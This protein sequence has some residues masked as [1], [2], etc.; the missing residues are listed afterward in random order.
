VVRY[1]QSV[2][3]PG[4]ARVLVDGEIVLEGPIANEEDAAGARGAAA[5]RAYDLGLMPGRFD[6][7]PVPDVVI[8]EY[9]PP[10]VLDAEDPVANAA[11]QAAYVKSEWDRL[12]NQHLESIRRAQLRLLMLGWSGPT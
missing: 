10:P 5:R 12:W 4:I 1:E 3:Y 6:G 7:V 11:R 9:P 2:T 8:V